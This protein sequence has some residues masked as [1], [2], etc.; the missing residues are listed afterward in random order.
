MRK[1]ER[2]YL[3][4]AQRLLP[5]CSLLLSTAGLLRHLFHAWLK[6]KII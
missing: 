2:A 1:R 6:I 3:A 4:G 5:T